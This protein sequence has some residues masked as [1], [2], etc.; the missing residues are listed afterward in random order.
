M[1]V[2]T[3]CSTPGENPDCP[4][5]KEDCIYYEEVLPTKEAP[6]PRP[7]DP[8]DTVTPWPC[9]PP[10]SFLQKGEVCR[11]ICN[12]CPDPCQQNPNTS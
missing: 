10:G 5:K 9:A 2:C 7:D 6:T 4:Q 12:D 3:M 11:S 1:I 8:F